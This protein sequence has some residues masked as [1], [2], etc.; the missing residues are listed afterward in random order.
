M[1]TFQDSTVSTGSQGKQP[2]R[3]KRGAGVLAGAGRAVTAEGGRHFGC[4]GDLVV[5]LRQDN[6][7]VQRQHAS[8][9]PFRC[10]ALFN[11]RAILRF[12]ANFPVLS[13]AFQLEKRPLAL[14]IAAIVARLIAKKQRQLVG[15][16]AG[17][18]GIVLKQMAR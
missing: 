6:V 8:A 1:D 11:D 10:R 17:E 9:L 12:E 4:C 18:E 2:G 5:P 14:V 3:L 7:G 13:D 15:S 16:V